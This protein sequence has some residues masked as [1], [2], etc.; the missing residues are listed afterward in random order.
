MIF[1]VVGHK[2]S[3]H[4]EIRRSHGSDNWNDC[5]EQYLQQLE[6]Y[7]VC[8]WKDSAGAEAEL[9]ALPMVSWPRFAGRRECG[10]VVAE[11]LLNLAGH[12]QQP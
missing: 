7:A 5:S 3:Q 11:R 4:R 9:C 2:A 10:Y 8:I 1:A 12:W 6:V